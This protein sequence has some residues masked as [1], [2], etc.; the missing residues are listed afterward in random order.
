MQ[1]IRRFCPPSNP[2][3]LALALGNF[4]GGH[5]GH[6]ALLQRLA[7]PKGLQRAV[8]TFE[9]HP[10]SVLRPN[11]N[12][13]RLCGVREKFIQLGKYAEIIYTP[14]FTT[15]LAATTAENFAE[16]LFDRL[17]ARHIIIGE[18]FRFGQKRRG[19]ADMLRQLAKAHNATVETTP[20]FAVNGKPVS[21]GRIRQHVQAGDFT[22]AAAM[23]GRPWTIGGKVQKGRGLGRQLGVPTANVRISFTPP[24]RGIF[25]AKATLEGAESMPAALSIGHNPTV[26]DKGGN[27]HVEAHILNF[28][29]ELYG[30]YLCLEPLKKIRD[31]NKYDS[32]SELKDAIF[33][34]IKSIRDFY[35]NKQKT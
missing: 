15:A 7:L 14:R 29:G 34:D 30:R 13:T 4:D 28:D 17:Q 26:N 21:S 20:L 25:A 6:Q 3:T 32:L 2:T 18:N 12:I 9:P 8:M 33:Q 11:V 22:A 16:L 19:D 27:L 1:I 10:L 24:C 31:E 35:Y 23:L 5:L